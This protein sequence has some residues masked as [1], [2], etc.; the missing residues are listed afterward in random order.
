MF[1]MSYERAKS[2]MH[3]DIIAAIPRSLQAKLGRD[4]SFTKRR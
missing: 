2:A 3:D 4:E 1:Y